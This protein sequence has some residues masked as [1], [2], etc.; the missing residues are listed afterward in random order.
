[1]YI[2]H[3]TAELAPIAKVGGLADVVYGLSKELAKQGHEVE[4]LLPKYDCI[5]YGQ[6]KHLKVAHRDLWSFEGP[7]RYNN[8]IWS[9]ELHNLN[10]LLLEPHHP[11]Y[12]FSRG[13][14]YGCHNDIDR[15]TYFSRT[16]LEYLLKAKK[17]PDVIH[18]HDWP[19]ALIA[20]LYKDMYTPLGLQTNGIV[21]T[22]HNLEHQGKCT[23][24][25]L[26]RV[27]LRGESYLT[28][29]KMQD[30]FS[31]DTINLLKGGIIYADALTTVSPNYEKEIKTPVGGCGLNGI[32]VKNQHKLSGILNGIDETF[33]NPESDPLLVKRYATHGVHSAKKEKEV[34]E[35]KAEN[36][37][38]VRTHLGLEEKNVPIVAS[39]TRIVHQKGP[40]LIIHA[41][42]RTLEKGGQFIFLGS[43]PS[44][45]YEEVFLSLKEE[46]SGNKNVA[47]CLDRDEALAHLIFAAAD[48]FIIPSLFEPCGLTQMIALRYGTIPIARA[49][50]GLVDTVFDIDTSTKPP[51]E[52]NGFS[53]DFPDTEGMNWALDRALACW[54]HDRPKWRLLMQQAMNKDFSWTRAAPEYLAIYEKLPFFS[55]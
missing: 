28:P 1:M 39:V 36:R 44:P 31:P 54:F 55:C 3:I 47:I 2:L 40:K 30:P 26:N 13:A 53:F 14:I 42:R 34:L 7:H 12:Y 6:L 19:T 9:A 32:L 11:A 24:H 23:P 5:E 27:G 8:T 48:L 22:I 20:P 10:I 51:Q 29:E 17:K 16:A 21:L 38:Y 45:E 35:G 41:I 46:L 43:S 50:G 52:R 18:I 15:F 37:K 49:T 25:H 4:I 33:W